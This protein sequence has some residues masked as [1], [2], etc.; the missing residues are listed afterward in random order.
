MTQ[1]KQLN[2]SNLS[3]AG[4]AGKDTNKISLVLLSLKDA[5][6]TPT[7]VWKKVKNV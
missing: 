3:L 7:V 1:E 4:G 2:L 5:T 6:S